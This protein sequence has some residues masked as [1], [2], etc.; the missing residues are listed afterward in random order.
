MTLHPVR[1]KAYE[2]LV[3]NGL[4]TKVQLI[5]GLLHLQMHTVVISPGPKCTVG[6]DIFDN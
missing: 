4:L 6:T 1:V 3:I 2:V 5:V